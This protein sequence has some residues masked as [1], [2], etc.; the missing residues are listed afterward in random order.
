[1]MD[2]SDFFIGGGLP[3]SKINPVYL[4]G[5]VRKF[6]SGNDRIPVP[7]T[8]YYYQLPPA[9]GSSPYNTPQYIALVD[10]S[11]GS[12]LRTYTQLDFNIANANQGIAGL[13][14]FFLDTSVQPAI[15]YC[16]GSQYAAGTQAFELVQLPADTAT[17]VTSTVSPTPIAGMPSTIYQAWRQSPYSAGG[18]IFPDG[19]GNLVI[20]GAV[21]GGVGSNQITISIATAAWTSQGA[22]WFP[23][24]PPGHAAYYTT[25]DGTIAVGGVIFAPESLVSPP[26]GM[27][28]GNVD[29]FVCADFHVNTIEFT[30]SASAFTDLVCSGTVPVLVGSDYLC[31]ISGY[32]GLAYK[33]GAA[34]PTAASSSFPNFFKRSDYDR[35][36]A[37]LKKYQLS[38]FI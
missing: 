7:G 16:A 6:P 28:G 23:S 18:F 12:V 5:F 1:M 8:T 13:N 21:Q 20:R 17:A 27:S 31:F 38:R 34:M 36:L 14:F 2:W 24:A 9:G 4:G 25:A 32:Q 35:L 26:A 3:F 30:G 15:L 33:A 10:N 29:Q 22:S 37:Q 11:T 19:N